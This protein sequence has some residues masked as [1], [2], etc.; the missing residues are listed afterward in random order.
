[1]SGEVIE[2]TPAQSVVE[3]IEEDEDIVTPG[4]YEVDP[5]PKGTQDM[6]MSGYES[7]SYKRPRHHRQL[8]DAWMGGMPDLDVPSREIAA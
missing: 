6:A 5:I 4:I 2:G 1:M 3:E 8:P 7:E